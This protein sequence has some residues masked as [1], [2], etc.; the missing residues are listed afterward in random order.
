MQPII[1]AR[2]L[3][4]IADALK[5][6]GYIILPAALP[7]R[8]TDALLLRV[9]SFAPEQWRQAGTGRKQAHRQQNIDRTDNIHW[10]DTDDP[11]EIAYAAWME[12][13]RLGLN[14]RLFLGLFDCENHFAVYAKG[15]YYR[16]HLDAFN[17]KPNRVVT[18]VFYL[19]SQITQADGGELLI[20]PLQGDIPI[21]TVR[22][23]HGKLV[24]F[25]SANFPHEVV[26]TQQ[27]RYSIAG[28][29]RVNNVIDHDRAH[30]TR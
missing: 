13:L 12:C 24:V 20:Y 23:G 14:R 25:L 21:E 17:G 29:F 22:P 18:T 10:L 16:R 27:T 4:A 3:D 11:A 5:D 7:A 15:D 8:L 2:L 9:K 6:P 1:T 28:W 19:N 26:M 30:P